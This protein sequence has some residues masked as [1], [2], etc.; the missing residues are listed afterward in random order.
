MKSKLE[1]VQ[2]DA[3]HKDSSNWKGM[4]YINKKDS[5]VFVPKLY[6]LLG[7]T[8]NFGNPYSYISLAGIIIII[9]LSSILF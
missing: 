3:M 8:L 5:R 1:Q 4:F 2:L 7:W 9:I 6:P